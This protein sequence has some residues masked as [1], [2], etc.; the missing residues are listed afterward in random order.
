[1]QVSSR[2]IGATN[3][4]DSIEEAIPA[5]TYKLDSAMEDKLCDLYDSRVQVLIS[6]VERLIIKHSVQ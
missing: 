4:P 3:C 1:M 6:T 5:E 2:Q